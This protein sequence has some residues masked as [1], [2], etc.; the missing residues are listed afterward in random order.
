MNAAVA[1]KA[2]PYCNI[3][4]ISGNEMKSAAEQLFAVLLDAQPTSIGGA[5]P[6]EDFYYLGK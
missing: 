1:Q 2:I 4:F 5:V 6:G 3:V